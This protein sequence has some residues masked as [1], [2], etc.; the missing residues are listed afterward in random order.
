M[1]TKCL[2]GWDLK[3][4][5]YLQNLYPLRVFGGLYVWKNFGV[6]FYRKYLKV[7]LI[8]K[9][10]RKKD[11]FVKGVSNISNGFVRYFQAMGYWLAWI[12]GNGRSI[13]VGEDPS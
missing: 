10:I 3:I 11:K 9:W 13:R 7:S 2:G 8:L 1:H 6:E 12:L 4:K 5:F